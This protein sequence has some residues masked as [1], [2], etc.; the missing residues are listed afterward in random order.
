MVLSHLLCVLLVTLA[1]FDPEHPANPGSYQLTAESADTTMGIVKGSGFYAQGDTVEI[2]ALENEGYHFVEWNDHVTENP[3]KVVLVRDTVFT[4]MFEAECILDTVVRHY[5]MCDGEAFI[6]NGEIYYDATTDTIVYGCDSVEIFTLTINECHV[7]A[8]DTVAV[9]PTE[10]AAEIRWPIWY[11]TFTYTLIIWADRN[12]QIVLCELTFN[13]VGFLID[14]RFGSLSYT[15][16]ASST[17]PAPKRLLQESV[18]IVGTTT[19]DFEVTGL[20]ANHTYYYELQALNMEEQTIETRSGSFTTKQD[21]PTGIKTAVD[22]SSPRKLLR[23][24]SLFILRGEQLYTITG[25]R[26]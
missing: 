24:G 1:S 17:L 9:N 23:N 2:E 12:R 19:L 26:Y 25:Q 7:E 15:A 5:A 4:A 11:G 10:N 3:R 20:E 18:I 13:E 22:S 6:H 21:M 16:Q 14:I 8:P